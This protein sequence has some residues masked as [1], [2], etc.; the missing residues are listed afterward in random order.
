MSMK[1]FVLMIT[2]LFLFVGCVSNKE[3][4]EE[5]TIV[6]LALF[7]NRR[8]NVVYPYYKD[9]LY[10]VSGNGNYRIVYPKK[11]ETS[12]GHVD[13]SDTFFT[14]SLQGT[15]VLVERVPTYLGNS[16]YNAWIMIMDGKKQK[17]V[18]NVSE[19]VWGIMSKP[20][21]EER[22]HL[23]NDDNYWSY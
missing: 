14:V 17:D 22:A 18:F 20:F 16:Y 7:G 8:I 2:A 1:T 19:I 13:F 10:I 11:I 23:L 21:D 12:S 6:P 15:K 5:D 3:I 4:A 9:S